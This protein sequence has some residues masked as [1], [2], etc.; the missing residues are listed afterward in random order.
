MKKNNKNKFSIT[1]FVKLVP[2]ITQTFKYVKQGQEGHNG[3]LLLTCEPVGMSK[4]LVKL[5]MVIV[6]YVI[7]INTLKHL[8]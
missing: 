7:H 3:L 1:L 6:V 4:M 5:V 2:T 8:Q